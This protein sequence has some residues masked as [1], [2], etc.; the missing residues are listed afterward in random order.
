MIGLAGGFASP[1][2]GGLY[3][4]VMGTTLFGSMWL[5]SAGLFRKAAEEGVSAR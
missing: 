1:G 5:V 2:A 4:V 3:E